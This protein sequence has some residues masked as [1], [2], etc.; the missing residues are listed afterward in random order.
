M[1]FS[2]LVGWMDRLNTPAT[3]FVLDA[4]D[5]IAKAVGIV[6]EVGMAALLAASVAAMTPAQMVL[7]ILTFGAWVAFDTMLRSSPEGRKRSA[8]AKQ[9][10]PVDES[11]KEDAVQPLRVGRDPFA[12]ASSS[13]STMSA[14]Q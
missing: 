13:E 4:I 12:R 1:L 11:S 2:A 14:C 9:V 5:V 7:G 8:A 10:G 6:L 3:H